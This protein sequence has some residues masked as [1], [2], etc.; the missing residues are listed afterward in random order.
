MKTTLLAPIS[1]AALLA[2]AAAAHGSVIAFDPFHTIGQQANAD[3]ANGLYYSNVDAASGSLAT[4]TDTVK[5]AI[6]AG[7]GIVGFGS[8]P[9][10]ASHTTFRL[11]ASRLVTQS[12]TELADGAVRI[13]N[14]KGSNTLPNND[15]RFASRQLDPYTPSSTYYMSSALMAFTAATDNTPGGYL[16]NGFGNS[17]IT[18]S[19]TVLATSASLFEGLMWGFRANETGDR[20]DLVVRATT[21]AANRAVSDFVILEGVTQQ[22]TYFLVARVDIDPTGAD[23]ITVWLDPDFSL[24]QPDG[25]ITFTAEAFSSTSAITHYGIVQSGLRHTGSNNAS[26]RVGYIDGIALGTTW[27]AVVPEPSTYALLLC[28]AALGLLVA[29]RRVA[30]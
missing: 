1:L 21:D 12:R 22:Q 23:T 15:H 2:A 28:A 16:L 18:D 30:R 25:G 6:T 10:V 14:F 9:W 20:I 5:N 26:N 27:V 7:G 24:S 4:H 11:Q 13:L 3:P 19:S 29:R 17:A 8:Q